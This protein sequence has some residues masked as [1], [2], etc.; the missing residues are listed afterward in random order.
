[1]F[2]ILRYFFVSALLTLTAGSVCAQSVVTHKVKKNETIYGIARE[3]G[4]T[5]DQLIAANPGMEQPGYTLKK[6]AVIN[7][8]VPSAILAS[9]AT[10]DVRQRAIRLGVVL[11]LHDTNGDGRRMIEYYRGILM[12]CDSMK[13]EGISVD[14][15]A[16]NTPDVSD[17]SQVIN[18]PDAARCDIII[19]PL[20]TKQMETLSRFVSAN[21]IKLVIPWSISSPEVYVNSNIFQIYQQPTE[22]MEST[23]RRF[24]DWF[25]QS[26]PII[27]DCDDPN[28]TKGAFTAVLRRQ[29]E[30]KGVQY[31]LTSLKSTDANFA[32]AFSAACQNVLVLNSS[33]SDDLKVV[34]LKLKSL[35]AANPNLQVAV[36]GYQEWFSLYESLSAGFHKYNMHI[37][38]PFYTNLGSA[39]TQKLSQQYRSY[40][41]H[42]M[43]N[44]FP[45]F[46][47]A[48]FDHAVYFLRG[49]HKYGS[50]FDGAAGRFGYQPV[51]T[52]L[53]F[54][55]AGNGGYLNR[56]FMFVHYKSDNL[57]ETINY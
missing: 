13:K 24:S 9:N 52:P 50:A 25:A 14:V 10:A 39:A 44:N 20:Y 2:R 51:Q 42:D 36:F 12:A 1:M 31:S 26:H 29:L 4:I 23:A 46:A 27:V 47:L 35:C 53:K 38:A 56:S 55:R 15:R 48:G 8:P 11:P 40:F 49:L 57:I 7:V 16:W 37:P 18:D 54:E 19:G 21:N 41:H 17:L 6:G 32:S 30:L 22:Q 43:Q 34:F 33:R 45:R 5:V 28:S 3:N